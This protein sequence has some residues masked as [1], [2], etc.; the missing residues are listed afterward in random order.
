MMN[1]IYNS[2]SSQKK[3]NSN[4]SNFSGQLMISNKLI[5]FHILRRKLKNEPRK[6]LSVLFTYMPKF[7][8]TYWNKQSIG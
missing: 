3:K 8:G 2:N 6:K 4:C 5:K 1:Q 7:N